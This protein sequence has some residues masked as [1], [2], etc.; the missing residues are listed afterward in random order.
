MELPFG[1]NAYENDPGAWSASLI[2]N[3]EML[4]DC[5]DAAS[6]RSLVE[7]G[8]YAGDLTRL[9]LLWAEGR[10]ARIVAVD[11]SPQPELE[12]LER[13]RDELELIRE[14]SLEALPHV[15]ATD[16]VI[17]DGD[18]NYYTVT[19]ELELVEQ[20]WTEQGAE[21]PLL[22]LHDVGWPHGRRDN[23]YDPERIPLE[24]RQPIAAGGG[25]YPGITGIRPGGLPYPWPAAEEGGARNGVLTAIEDFIATRADLR[26][27]IFP[28]FFGLGVLYRGQ[29]PYAEALGR[30]LGPWDRHP[31]L[32]RLER[33]RV[34]HLASSHVQLSL[35]LDAQRQNLRQQEL[36]QEMLGSRIFGMAEFVLRLR[37]AGRPAF[38]KD[39]IR[40]VL[41]GED[42][43]A[44]ARTENGASAGSVRKPD[45]A[46]P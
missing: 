20:R 26:L 43:G 4:L 25:L 31:L 42:A 28:P 24:D 33:N 36:F 23:Y 39:Q 12:Q 6:V 10:D 16:A 37:Q 32:E 27:A 14:T 8:A 5:L 7:I 9:L 29:A 18:H 34:L 13:E 3:A 45:A 40:R 44:G 11:P 38:S 46:A 41:R 1:L 30:L 35:A 15:G 19:R 21:L 17:I 22:L 2:N